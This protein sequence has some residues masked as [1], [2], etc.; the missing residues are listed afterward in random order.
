MA[1]GIY[2]VFRYL[3]PQG[4]EFTTLT[5]ALYY[6]RR[7]HLL[8]DLGVGA[9]D[10]RGEM[11]VNEG[12]HRRTTSCRLLQ[13]L[14][15]GYVKRLVFILPAAPLGI[16]QQTLS[17]S[18][19]SEGPQDSCWARIG[20]SNSR[21]HPQILKPPSDCLGCLLCPFKGFGVVI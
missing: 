2:S 13:G 4:V 1:L 9:K 5:Q 19:E 14:E 3:D 18:K 11:E 6:H 17:P 7:R 16:F 12:N 20:K 15:K 21:R 10:L 8:R